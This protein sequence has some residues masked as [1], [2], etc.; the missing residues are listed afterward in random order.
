MGVHTTLVEKTMAI[1]RIGKAAAFGLSVLL[2][3]L[4]VQTASAANIPD[5][6]YVVGGA[7]S[8]ASPNV[9]QT[10]NGS[11]S[12][13]LPVYLLADSTGVTLLTSEGGLG[14]AGF[15]INRTSGNGTITG[16]TPAETGTDFSGL[17]TPWVMTT[18]SI[19]QGDEGAANG[20]ANG[21]KLGN[22]GSP[23][24][25]ILLGTVTFTP[26]TTTTVF[27]L[28]AQ[29]PV[30]GGSTFTNKN[31]YD[32]DLTDNGGSP[33]PTY[34]GVGSNVATFTLVTPSPEPGSLGLLAVGGLMALKRR[35]R[36]L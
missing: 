1:S 11:N 12:V 14:T 33:P 30:N 16:F 27:T 5:F 19:T 18:T 25:T 9:S 15:N 20:Q 21:V 6:L 17:S 35:R 10:A 28:S 32:L 22:D 34:V 31:V 13:V 29:D 3:G 23:S 36:M 8:T 26:G 2:S 4:A 24:N 7:A